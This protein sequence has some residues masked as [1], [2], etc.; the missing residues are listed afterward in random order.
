MPPNRSLAK[1]Q[2]AIGRNLSFVKGVL[3]QNDIW[4]SV[5]PLLMANN[6]QL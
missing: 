6:S 2:R 4:M 5:V 1:D 3:T